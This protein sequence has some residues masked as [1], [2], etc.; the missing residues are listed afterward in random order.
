MFDAPIDGVYAWLGVAVVSIAVAAVAVSLPSTVPPD[1]S[2]VAAQIDRVATSEHRVATSI[3]PDA[4][5]MRVRASQ[6][7]LRRDGT[8]AH[9]PLVGERVVTADTDALAALLAGQPAE[10]VYTDRAA[11][12]RAVDE[13]TAGQGTWRPA[14]EHLQIRRVTWGE[15]DVTVVG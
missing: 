2:A 5:A 11:F 12:A 13:V 3:Q 8:T 7:S 6:V 1:A 10:S 14:P 4:D 9:A 15:I